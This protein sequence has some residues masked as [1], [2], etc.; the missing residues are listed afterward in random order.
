MLNVSECTHPSGRVSIVFSGLV[1]AEGSAGFAVLPTP[2]LLLRYCRLALR[3]SADDQIR[4]WTVALTEYMFT[5]GALFAI[6]TRNGSYPSYYTCNQ[7]LDHIE[8]GLLRLLPAKILYASRPFGLYK[9]ASR[10]GA[11]P[12]LTTLAFHGCREVDRSNTEVKDGFVSY[13]V[14]TGKLY[15]LSEE[16]IHARK[17]VRDVKGVPTTVTLNAGSVT[18]CADVY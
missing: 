14:F 18:V 15:H 7:R 12:V 17:R 13:A 10:M 9:L 5:A 6:N 8:G 3:W 11:D 2:L 4:I 16:V 1:V